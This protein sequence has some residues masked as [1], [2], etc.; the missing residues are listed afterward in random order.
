ML[1][2]SDY[3]M[4]CKLVKTSTGISLDLSKKYLI[5]ARLSKF[6]SEHGFDGVES[7]IDQMA[8]PS[9][10]DLQ[11]KVAHSLL[12]H[13]TLFFRDSRLFKSMF[14]EILPS[15]DYNHNLV[16][17]SAACSTGQEPYSIAMSIQE[18]NNLLKTKKIEIFASDISDK[19]VNVAKQ[20]IYNAAE[21]ARGVNDEVLNKYF[22]SVGDDR[23]QVVSNLRDNI[24]FK[25]NNLMMSSWNL[26]KLDVVFMRNVLIYFQKSER[27]KILL[28][29]KKYLNDGGIVITG[30][31]ED[32]SAVDQAFKKHIE[33][34]IVFFRLQR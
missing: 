3:L 31:G 22:R 17:W 6:A 9:S 10:L 33:C 12:T 26:P 29:L 2:D 14:E 25:V 1:S 15:Y 19:V 20:G 23:W 24:T 34:G 21:I 32:I 27:Q 8:R 5:D 13:E 28:T 16:I 4:I 30:T 7:L 11:K 18:A